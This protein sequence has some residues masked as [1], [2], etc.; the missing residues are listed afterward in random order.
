MRQRLAAF[1]SLGLLGLVA[2]PFACAE[3]VSSPGFTTTT[4]SAGSGGEG[5]GTGGAGGE[6]GEGPCVYAE[7][8]AAFTDACN[9]GT[10]INGACQKM[11]AN[12]NA[13]CDDGKQCTTSDHCEAG[14]C[15]GPLKPCTATAACQ[16]GMC[17]VATDTCVEVPGNDGAGCVDEDPCSLTS[18]CDGGACVTGQAVDCTF[19]DS[20]CAVGTCDPAVGC[21]VVPKN[22][23][24]G[25]D[26]GFF[27][28]INDACQAGL[29]AGAVNTCTAVGDTCNV[30]VCNEAAD[31][32]TVTP[33]NNGG[34]CSDG[35]DCT[36]G[37]TCLNG[38]CLGGQAANN[39]ANCDDQDGCTSGTTCANGTCT[40]AASTITMCIDADA[41]CPPGCADSDCLYWVSG[42]QKNLPEANLTGWTQCF[43][44]DYGNYNTP[45]SQVK[46]QCDGAKLLMGCKI[47]GTN[48][49]SLAGMAN[50]ADV[51]FDCGQ[52][53]DCKHDAN[54]VGFY[55][56]DSWSWGF[57]PTNSTV[58]RN[59]C[60]VGFGFDDERMCWH[61]GGGFM[62][63]GYRCGNNYPFDA[64]WVRV[65]Y[66]AN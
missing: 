50:A 65:V 9:S 60:D 31:K 15:T 23:G 59:S 35:N 1:A 40:G 63:G 13:P 30:G 48:T 20:E 34:A 33:G 22:D 62:N 11:A 56:S 7:D 43:S 24:D 6:G 19:L 45:L 41:C 14:L 2:A 3:S 21:T 12:E 36:A 28:T 53:N 27:C 44:D 51:Y 47:A 64:S 55:Y 46:Q 26:D 17:D 10:C 52:T 25:C 39:G 61:T 49:L 42:I 16:V 29:C 66:E 37:E 18:Y 5:G 58:S 8:C 38:T 54:G 4:T 32:C 57:A